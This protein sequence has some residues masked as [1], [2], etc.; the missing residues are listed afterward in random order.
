VTLSI[1]NPEDSVDDVYS[2]KIKSLNGKITKFGAMKGWSKQRVDSFTVVYTA[3]TIPLEPE[4]KLKVMIGVSNKD[5]KLKWE[6]F[7]DEKESL[8]MGEVQIKKAKK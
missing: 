5:P 7:S 8:G 1:E 2:I 6:A 3:K 4:G